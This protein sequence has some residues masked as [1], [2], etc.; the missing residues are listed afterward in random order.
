MH[1]IKLTDQ[2]LFHITKAIYDYLKEA[3]SKNELYEDDLLN[4]L[5][6]IDKI[7]EVSE[8]L[9]LDEPEVLN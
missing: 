5:S 3:E 9:I 2:E 8:N 7:R 4:M 1:N 6:V